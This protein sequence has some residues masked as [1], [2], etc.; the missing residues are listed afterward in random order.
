VQI[1]RSEI[2]GVPVL[3]ADTGPGTTVGALLFGVGRSDET[4]ATGGITHLVEH[5]A[6]A[7]FGQR[8]Y[9]T[10]GFVDGLRSVFHAAGTPEEVAD[11]LAA[12]ATSLGDIE[13][14]RLALERRILR[15]EAE[16]AGPSVAGALVWYRFGATGHGLPGLDEHGLTWL[17]PD[18]L[19][20][21]VASWYTRDNAVVWLSG[22]P[23][24]TLRL[25][26]PSG[27]PP[28]RAPVAPLAG[29]EYPAHVPWLGPGVAMSYLARR[30]SESN[31]VAS[32]LE[33]RARQRLRFDKGLVYDIAFDYAPL[34]ADVAHVI[35]GADCPDDRIPAVRAALL[36]VMD[37]LAAAGPTDA[38]LA[39]ERSAHARSFEDREARLAY[40]DVQAAE[41]LLGQPL[42]Q[43]AEQIERRGAVTAVG[44][45]EALEEGMRSRMMLA[46]GDPLTDPPWHVYPA[47]SAD[48]VSGKEFRAAGFHLPG[49]MPKERLVVGPD[50]VSACV[51]EGALTVRWKDVVAVIHE[52]PSARIVIGADGFQVGV[53]GEAWRH[54][55]D[56]VAAIDAAIPAEVVACAEHGIGALD[57]PEP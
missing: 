19:R 27:T 33:R 15:D 24:D 37:E 10:N 46:K 51:P 13:Y 50:G 39:A 42:L 8:D 2:D 36:E 21:W 56:V 23:P 30:S 41:W 54:G 6:L 32:V 16:Q 52:S 44:A 17:G 57:A 47:W 55:M 31:V 49:R 12:V 25:A 38:E 34:S 45:R 20:A 4:A 28:Q 1:E 35:V 11:H 26:L 7:P 40:L 43:P 3:W 22:P 53:A 9:D 14:D 29:I 5:L 48:A 18:R